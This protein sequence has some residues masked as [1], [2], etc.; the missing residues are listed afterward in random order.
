MVSIPSLE[1]SV[2]GVNVAATGPSVIGDKE[3]LLVS[4]AL[5]GDC[6]LSLLNNRAA[7]PVDAFRE[8]PPLGLPP[9]DERDG[10]VARD[11]C[12]LL[13]ITAFGGGSFS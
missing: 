3:T 7:V 2:G 8:A 1:G 11:V 6:L 12:E 9:I 5:S 4:V 10:G 13:M